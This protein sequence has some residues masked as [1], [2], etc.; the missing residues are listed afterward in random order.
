MPMGG[1]APACPAD[2]CGEGWVG[3]GVGLALHQVLS[4]VDH[5]T[6]FIF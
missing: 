3:V 1:G 4:S 5:F 6:S 2:T